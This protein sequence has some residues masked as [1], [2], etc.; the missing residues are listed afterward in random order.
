MY[1]EFRSL[2]EKNKILF[3]CAR[4]FF[5]PFRII[6]EKIARRKMANDIIESHRDCRK[7]TK[8]IFY[9]GV[10]EHNNLG[11]LGQT[12]CTRQWIE[13]NYPDYKLIEMRT[14]AAFDKHM[15]TFMKNCLSNEDILLLQSG[16]CTRDKNPDHEM[17]KVIA[18]VFPGN[19][20]VVLPQTVLL[21]SKKEIKR[22]QTIF[23]Q[24]EHLLFI[25]R[26]ILSFSYAKEF[27][28]EKQ[29]ACFPDIVTSLI[30]QID[31]PHTKRDGALLCIRNDGE[32]FYQDN[33]LSKLIHN[34]QSN[35][36]RVER[37]D[38]NSQE[39]VFSIYSH[40]EKAIKEMILNFSKYEVIIT[41]RYHGTIFALIANTPV[42]IIKTN[43]HK[44]TSGLDWFKDIFDEDAV[45]LANSLE[46]AQEKARNIHYK[47]PKIS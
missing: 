38:T 2:V 32:K 25:C 10:P 7:E 17:H 47:K 29:I 31:V 1:N 9:I 26:D 40:L 13:K 18:S 6:R 15:Q 22:T 30:G 42:I 41:D 39:D 5:T 34:L 23:S 45:Q 44:V 19:K 27:T 20:I 33:E 8:K 46:E 21:K 36:K 3:A 28:N 43:D 4:F 11:D 35:F 16:Y 14:R 37:T 24:C 12:Y